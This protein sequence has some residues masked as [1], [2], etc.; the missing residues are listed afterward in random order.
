MTRSSKTTSAEELKGM[1][2]QIQKEL[3]QLHKDQEALIKKRKKTAM[4]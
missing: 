4:W 3:E 2:K 1:E